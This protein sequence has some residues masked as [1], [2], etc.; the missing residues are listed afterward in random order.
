MREAFQKKQKIKMLTFLKG[1]EGVDFY[2]SH[3]A[4]RGS[5]KEEKSLNLTF[6]WH[7]FLHISIIH[8]NF[9]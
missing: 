3:L 5:E 9:Y 7:F 6:F 2:K 8:H 1:E 4:Q